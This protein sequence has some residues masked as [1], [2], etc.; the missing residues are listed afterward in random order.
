MQNTQEPWDKTQAEILSVSG[1][2]AKSAGMY[3]GLNQSKFVEWIILK[4]KSSNSHKVYMI[5][6][7]GK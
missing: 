5:P 7:R 4:Y 6:G 3:P 1:I 2:A